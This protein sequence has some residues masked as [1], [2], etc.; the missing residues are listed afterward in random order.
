M[1]EGRKILSAAASA[2][3][4]FLSNVMSASVPAPNI[5]T[6]SRAGL[7]NLHL[8]TPFQI[9]SLL[10]YRSRCGDILSAAEL[11]S[12][13][14][15]GEDDIEALSSAVIFD[16]SPSSAARA[17]HMASFKVKKAYAKKGMT[18]TAKY[19]MS[20]QDLK[21]GAV[22]DDDPGGRFP[23]FVSAHVSWK[24]FMAGDF[25]ACLGQGLIMWKGMTFSSL[26]EPSSI[27][28]RGCGIQGYKSSDE[29]Q[30][31]RGAAYSG[32]W[33]TVGMDVFCALNHRMVGADVS[34]RIG[35]WKF[36]VNAVSGL[37]EG[38]GLWA[39]AS[40]D[41]MGSIGNLRLFGELA[42]SERLAPAVRLGSI[43]RPLYELE[44]SCAVWAYAPAYR[45]RHSAS[46]VK[47]QAG[48]ELAA[49]YSPGR[50]KFNLNAAYRY[51]P[52]DG[53]SSMKYRISVQYSFQD[54]S[55]VLYH[56]RN[57]Q[58]R[59]D[60]K[61]VLGDWRLG[62]RAE[63]NLKGFG[64]Y[65]DV[66]YRHRRFEASAR[67]TYYDTRDWASRI[68]LYERD[69]PQSFATVAYYGKGTGE[70]LVVKYSPVRYA[71]F[72]LKV[73]QNYLAFFTRITIP[74]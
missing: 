25:K 48:A 63:G 24:G 12:V 53:T 38:G 56:F 44:L 20:S 65:A 26:G 64:L 16:M 27:L 1:I 70:Y 13:D 41:F 30:Y 37:K 58:H 74:G 19:E 18:L 71:E 15:F 29:S 4:F 49:R 23:D 14:G 55:S 5:N 33:G 67:F 2:A 59:L 43:W 7:E 47:D 73:Q 10:D 21:C 60:G 66:T 52:S 51:K 42:S 36:G 35:T 8:L 11:S 32:N 34:K 54:G 61:L 57:G 50:W 28:R 6:L 68:Y 72:W 40:M 45:A 17:R 69:V 9:E 39:D 46:S 31:L 62:A 22:V 3:F